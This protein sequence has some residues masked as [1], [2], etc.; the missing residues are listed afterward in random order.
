MSRSSELL[1]IAADCLEEGGDPFHESFLTRNGVTFDECFD[2][3]DSLSVGAR[4]IA[5]AMEN[6][7][8]AAA[9]ARSGADGVKMDAIPRLLAK[10]SLK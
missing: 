7:K 5:W 2:L 1:K 6:P 9:F 10:I 4:L 3:A 8:Q